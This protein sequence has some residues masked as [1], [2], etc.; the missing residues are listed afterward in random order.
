MA[1]SRTTQQLLTLREAAG[2][3]N[4]HPATLRRWAD[5]G[6]V[7]VMVTPGGH[8][9][10]PVSE[11]ER[12]SGDRANDGNAESVGTSL[13]EAAINNARSEIAG[14]PTYSWAADMDETELIQMRAMGRHVMSLLERFVAEGDDDSTLIRAAES[15]GREYATSTKG[16]GMNLSAVL[17]AVTFFRDRILEAAVSLPAAARMDQESSRR[18]IRRVNTFL[19]TILLSVAASFEPKP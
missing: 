3:L 12:L 7:L 1:E 11:I 16:I 10:F 4:V 15:M 13:V 18:L 19:N 2:R 9:R 14:H 5:K 8:R 17:Q 6:D